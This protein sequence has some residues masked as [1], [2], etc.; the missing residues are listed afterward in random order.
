MFPG[1]GVRSGGVGP[2]FVT[3]AGT[4]P[5]AQKRPA[6]PHSLSHGLVSITMQDEGALAR[7]TAALDG[8]GGNRFGGAAAASAEE[9]PGPSAQS[10]EPGQVGES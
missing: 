7:S 2:F 3:R 1:A 4:R 5:L 10:H 9:R 6:G 8:H